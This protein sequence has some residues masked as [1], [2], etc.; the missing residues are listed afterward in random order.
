[1]IDARWII[2]RVFKHLYLSE[3]REIRLEQTE[4]SIYLV[5]QLSSMPLDSRIFEL[6]IGL[7]ALGLLLVVSIKVIESIQLLVGVSGS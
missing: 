7:E 5:E 1:M 4:F 6:R 3:F 2:A